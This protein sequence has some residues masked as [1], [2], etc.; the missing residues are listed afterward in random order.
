MF[1][2]KLATLG[3]PLTPRRSGGKEAPASSKDLSL[4]APAAT[5]FAQPCPALC[6]GNR[7][8]IYADRPT[9]CRDFECALFKSVAAGEKAVPAALRTIRTALRRAE[10]V[11]KLLRSLGNTDEAVALSLRFKHTRRRIESGVIDKPTAS[12]FADLSIAQHD[13][14]LLLARSFYPGG[15]R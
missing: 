6:A 14:N 4:G 3:L 5:K 8:R 2:R 1:T 12:T 15:P 13:L 10:K 9:R 7:C 11:R